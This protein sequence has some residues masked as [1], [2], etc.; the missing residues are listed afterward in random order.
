MLKKRLETEPLKPTNYVAI[1]YTV[2]FFLSL[3][4]LIFDIY[5]NEPESLVR[6]IILTGFMFSLSLFTWIIYKIHF[7][8][9]MKELDTKKLM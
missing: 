8:L 3:A 4:H 6:N 1:S 2:I 5:N 7:K 9:Y